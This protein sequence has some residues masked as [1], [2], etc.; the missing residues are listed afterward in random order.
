MKKTTLFILAILLHT[1]VFAQ[2]LAE[3]AKQINYYYEQ[4]EQQ[5]RAPVLQIK[6]IQSFP[7]DKYNFIEL[8]NSHEEDL[9]AEHGADYVKKFR[10]L[11]D[12]FPDSVLPRSIIIAK[13]MPAWSAGAVEELQKGIYLITHKHP[14]LFVDVVKELKKDEQ[15]SLAKFLYAGADGKNVNYDILVD[16]LDR[17]AERKIKKIFIEAPLEEPEE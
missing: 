10:K 6:Y 14:Q 12:E 1:N 5:P 9:L 7:I 16:I 13:D 15:A 2:S 3:Q 8:F 11:G 17:A 4:L